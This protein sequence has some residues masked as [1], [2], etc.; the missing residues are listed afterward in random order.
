[1]DE[2]FSS[3]NPDE[4]VAGAY[5]IANNLSNYKNNICL[6][7]THYNYLTK[8]ENQGKFKNYKISIE[9]DNKNK[10]ICI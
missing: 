10:I 7:T 3:T 2:I 5:A 4:G 1:M 8:L 9:R 6:L